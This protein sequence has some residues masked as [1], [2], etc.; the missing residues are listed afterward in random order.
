MG[1]HGDKAGVL[2][3]GLYLG[4]G[5]AVEPGQLYAVVA[6]LLYFLHGAGEIPLG[7]LPDGVDLH[8]DGQLVHGKNLLDGKMLWG[9]CNNFTLKHPKGQDTG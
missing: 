9:L 4:G 5:E 8:G 1:R 2:D 6:Y 3:G 7:V